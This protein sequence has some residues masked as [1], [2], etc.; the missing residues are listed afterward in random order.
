[1]AKADRDIH[2]FNRLAA[3]YDRHWMQRVIFEPVQRTVLDLAASE[4]SRPAA[5][6]DIGCG[7]GRLLR[8]AARRFPE[9]MLT[10]VDAASEMVRQAQVL[11]PDG[12]IAFRQARAEALP[13]AVGAFTLV[14]ST[15]TFHHW[16]DQRIA[17][18]EVARV[19][20]PGGR[21][22]IADFMATGVVS[23]FRRLLR[24]RQFPERSTLEPML[25]SAGLAVVANRTVRGFGGQIGVL[26][27]GPGAAYAEHPSGA[28]Q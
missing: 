10:G 20:A 4:V 21:W 8:S 12:N 18:A 22:L 28:G 27:I 5:I 6:L 17:I 26:A 23:Y 1:V 16:A 7:T 15:L 14:F 2:R 19:L 24:L 11:A 9:A 13:F 25:S 3:H